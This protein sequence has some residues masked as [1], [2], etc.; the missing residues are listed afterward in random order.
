MSDKSQFSQL[1][2][3]SA[4]NVLSERGHSAFDNL[5]LKLDAPAPG[6]NLQ[7]KATNL[8][9]FA[10]GNTDRQTR[11]GRKLGDAIVFEA[12]IEL[13]NRFPRQLPWRKQPNAYPTFHGYQAELFRNL[14]RDGFGFTDRGELRRN[15]PEAVDLPAADD[16]VHHFL[17]RFGLQIPK[18]HLD[19]ALAAHTRGDWAAANSQL[20]S[21]LEGLLDTIA[22]EIDPAKAKS[23]PVGNQRR[24]LLANAG[25]L[26]RDLNE[27][28]DD[29]KGF[30]NAF[31]K[32]LH[33]QGSHPGLSDEED[34]TFRLHLV[35]LAA[36]NLLRRF[37]KQY[38]PLL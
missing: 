4:A 7:T 5:M 1:T 27:W 11:D 10:L 16:E 17:D 29:A 38:R 36:R 26:N 20:R 18:G 24:Q 3:I 12:A 30:Y 14:A 23:T 25:F 9:A 22:E 6:H 8:A 28:S 33:P 37:S 2:I 35:L 32:R 19:Q 13:T 31:F 15:L 34:S 21:F